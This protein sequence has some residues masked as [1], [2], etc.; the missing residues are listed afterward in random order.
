[1]KKLLIA[2]LASLLVIPAFADSTTTTTTYESETISPVQ[3]EEEYVD[4][5][6][7]PDTVDQ[8]REEKRQEMEDR[9]YNSSSIIESD[10]KAIDYTDRT[11]TNRERH[12]INTGSDASDDQ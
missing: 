3:E 4:Q 1:M 11:R 12:A 7:P 8:T 9:D 2:S 10:D 5:P 6:L